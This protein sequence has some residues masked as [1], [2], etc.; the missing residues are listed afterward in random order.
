[1]PGDTAC[2]IPHLEEVKQQLDTLPQRIIADAGYGSEENYTYLEKEKLEN[3]VKFNLFHKEQKRSWRKQRFRVENWKYEKECDEYICPENQ[4]LSFLREFNKKTEMG[5]LSKI[6]EYECHKLRRMS[7]E[8]RMYSCGRQ[9]TRTS[10]L[11]IKS[12]SRSSSY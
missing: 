9:S 11:Q 2:L 5:Y 10:E 1:M 3:Y 8:I 4:K 7:D 12:V 6:R